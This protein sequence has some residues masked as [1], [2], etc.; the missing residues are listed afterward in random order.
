MQA[1]INDTTFSLQADGASSNMVATVTYD[2]LS[3]TA[4]LNPNTDLDYDTL[5]HVTV[6]GSVTDLSNNSI[7]QRLHVELYNADCTSSK[8]N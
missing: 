5:Y 7:G 2:A 3:M 8:R 4:T 1:S 6:S